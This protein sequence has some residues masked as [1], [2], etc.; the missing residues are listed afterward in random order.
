MQIF[1]IQIVTP[2]CEQL[3]Y[4]CIEKIVIRTAMVIAILQKYLHS[5]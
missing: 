5:S 4:V 3:L 2:G 1:D